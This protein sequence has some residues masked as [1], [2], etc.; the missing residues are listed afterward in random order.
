MG[1]T[2]VW[3]GVTQRLVR[4][5][6]SSAVAHGSAPGH[7]AY[8]CFHAMPESQPV[9]PCLLRR[10]LQKGKADAATALAAHHSRWGCGPMHG[11]LLLVISTSQPCTACSLRCPALS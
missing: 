7:G 6:G 8:P 4:A 1:C 10:L 11:Q 5:P 2:C 3:A 9:L